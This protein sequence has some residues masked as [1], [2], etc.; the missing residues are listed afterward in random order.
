MWFGW[1]IDV[2]APGPDRGEGGKYL[3]LPPDY[4]GPLP[5]S[6]FHVGRSRTTHALYAVC[7]FMENN[8]PKPA[9]AAIKKSLKIYLYTPGGF[10]TS[11]ATALAGKVRLEGNRPVSPTKFVE[12]SGKSF[13][14]IPTFPISECS[15]SS[16]RWSQPPLLI[17]SSWANWRPLAS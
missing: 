10:G 6:G 14:T 17:S 11:I 4:D 1:I 7:A 9:V 8:D 16:F 13:S 2:G 3:I 15:T 5:D 12:A